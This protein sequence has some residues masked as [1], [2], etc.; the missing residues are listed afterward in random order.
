MKRTLLA[1]VSLATIALLSCSFDS[2]N[3][4]AEEMNL[5]QAQALQKVMPN[6]EA[7][8]T[9]TS[10]SYTAS[11]SIG[12]FTTVSGET[13]NSNEYIFTLPGTLPTDA[14]LT[15]VQLN[16][17]SMTSSGAVVTNYWQIR[18]GI[19]KF[20]TITC[21]AGSNVNLSTS[22]FNG[23]PTRDTYYVSFSATCAGLSAG[24]PRI[25]SKSYSS[26]KL[27]LDYCQP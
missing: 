21:G 25:C 5:P 2:S 17:G 1:F 22:F 19:S 10:K 4:L 7:Q 24:T 27:I 23:D 6:D 15:K 8:Q 14:V 13:L 3:P 12:I 20:T 18:K 11:Q 9:C 16:T 26:V